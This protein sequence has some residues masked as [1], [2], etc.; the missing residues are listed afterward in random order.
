MPL[1]NET[2]DDGGNKYCYKI[3]KIN[4]LFL[5]WK[6]NILISKLKIIYFFFK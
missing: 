3:K 1:Y 5:K 2:W 4:Y 6:K